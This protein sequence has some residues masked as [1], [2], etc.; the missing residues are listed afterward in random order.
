M[1]SLNANSALPQPTNANININ[2]EKN[3]TNQPIIST[4]QHESVDSNSNEKSVQ[5]KSTMKMQIVYILG[6]VI[7]MALVAF[8]ISFFKK[9]EVKLECVRS[10]GSKFIVKFDENGIKEATLNGKTVKESDLALYQT[11]F[12]KDFLNAKR[13]SEKYEE[14]F[15]NIVKKFE[16][17]IGS[18]CK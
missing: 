1:P 16:E 14:E 11:Q 3:I 15:K 12:S 6:G 10:T 4:K 7:L 9:S 17:D 13:S 18:T 8:G 2:L 5:K